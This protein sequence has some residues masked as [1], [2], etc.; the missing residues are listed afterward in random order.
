MASPYLNAIRRQR[1][2]LAPVRL[3]ALQASGKRLVMERLAFTLFRLNEHDT[4]LGVVTPDGL[5]C[6][7][8]LAG[9]YEIEHRGNAGRSLNFQARASLGNIPNR[10]RDRMLSEKDFPGLQH[11]PSRRRLT[12]IHERISSPCA[13]GWSIP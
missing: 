9:E 6:S 1:I 11:S 13:G 2:T 12:S 7:D 10:A 4:D 3:I 8:G 5:A